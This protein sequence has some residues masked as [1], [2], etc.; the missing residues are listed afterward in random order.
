MK[1]TTINNLQKNKLLKKSI[2]N[3][4]FFVNYIFVK[5]FILYLCC[6]EKPIRVFR[7]DW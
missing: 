1:K 6:D 4:K 2:I 7:A 3:L 5:T